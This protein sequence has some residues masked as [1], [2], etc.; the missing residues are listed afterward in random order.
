M[1]Q[2]TWLCAQRVCARPP[3]NASQHACGARVCAWYVHARVC[4]LF[5]R[6]V[7]CVDVCC[8]ARVA[9]AR[10]EKDNVPAGAGAGRGA[11]GGKGVELEVGGG[12]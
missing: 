10:D 11:K 1:P 2:H 7:S 6:R 8:A 3:L 12:G 9:Q 5:G 4:V